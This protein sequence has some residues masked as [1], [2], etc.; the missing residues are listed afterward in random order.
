[1]GKFTNILLA[2]VL[3]FWA[4][5]FIWDSSNASSERVGDLVQ[6]SEKS[7]DA[8]KAV[9]V[10]LKLN[11]NPSNSEVN[12]V[13]QK[14]D[15]LLVRDLARKQTGDMSLKT[16]SEIKEEQSVQ[17]QEA[18]SKEMS[19]PIFSFWGFDVTMI[20]LIMFCIPFVVITFGIGFMRRQN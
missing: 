7:V 8:K 1:M 15:E 6:K 4:L 9:A 20:T 11:P 14:V 12:L 10:L 16:S 5:I 13:E 19:K 3:I 2:G 18:L 17:N